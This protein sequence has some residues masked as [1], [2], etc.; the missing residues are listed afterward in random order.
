MSLI[1][2]YLDWSIIVLLQCQ[3]NSTS[4]WHAEHLFT[5]QNTLY[6]QALNLTGS[7]VEDLLRKQPIF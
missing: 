7:F 3:K 4:E 2:K 5:G 1:K 6:L